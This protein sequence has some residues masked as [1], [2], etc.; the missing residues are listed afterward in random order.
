MKERERKKRSTKTQQNKQETFFCGCV[1]FLLFLFSFLCLRFLSF[2][3][4][5]NRSRCPRSKS[6]LNFNLSVILIM[7]H[8]LSEREKKWKFLEFLLQRNLWFFFL[9]G[10]FCLEKSRANQKTSLPEKETKKKA[11]E[12]RKERSDEFVRRN[13]ESGPEKNRKKH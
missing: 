4:A 1:F 9:S 2:F 3:S 11:N 7:F 12:N 8:H 10:F 6:S 5:G 13:F